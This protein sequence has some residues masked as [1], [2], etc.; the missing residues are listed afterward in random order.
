M[1]TLLKQLLLP[2]EVAPPE[3]VIQPPLTGTIQVS[4]SDSQSGLPDCVVSKHPGR[5]TAS[6]QFKNNQFIITVPGKWSI[7]QQQKAIASLHRRLLKQW[8]TSVGLPASTKKKGSL[9]DDVFQQETLAITSLQALETVVTSINAETFK[10]PL[11]GVRVG[12]AKYS[13]LAYLKPSSGV[14]TFSRYVLGEAIPAEAFRYLVVHELAHFTEQNHS[15]RFWA[16]VARHCPDYK[17]Q[18]AV[19]RAFFQR[20]VANIVMP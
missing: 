16:L 3:P 20:Q 9:T 18:R 13:S 15:A 17:I 4:S 19:I 7:D 12:N 14:V 2:L 6:G 5:K 8:H 1:F 11:K 10:A